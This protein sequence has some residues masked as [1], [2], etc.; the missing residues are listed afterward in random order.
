MIVTRG[1]TSN[2]IITRGYGS[3]F[4]RN[5]V[6]VCLFTKGA[7][8]RLFSRDKQTVLFKKDC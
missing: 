7:I 1:F 6:A 8:N 3:S 4:I 2:S 5:I